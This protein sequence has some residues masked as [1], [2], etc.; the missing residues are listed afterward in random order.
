ML[1]L[2]VYKLNDYFKNEKQ[3]LSETQLRSKVVQAKTTVSSQVS[4]LKNVLSS[5]ETELA[6]TSINWVQLDPF[7]AI[8]KVEDTGR[9]LKVSKLLVRSNTPAER[10][11]EL[12]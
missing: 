7:F 10:W 1:A 2:V 12:Y 8:A 6:D 3:F 11:N 9:S 4:Q 5:Y